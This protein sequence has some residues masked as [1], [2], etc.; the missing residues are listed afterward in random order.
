MGDKRWSI[1]AVVLLL[2]GSNA[3][4]T[5]PANPISV[6]E[7]IADTVGIGLDA[8]ITVRVQANQD[9]NSVEGIIC[10]SDGFTVVSQL[11]T[12][13]GSL[14]GGKTTLMHG[15]IQPAQ[16]GVWIL[17]VRCFGETEDS[18]SVASNDRVVLHISDTLCGA[19]TLSQYIELVGEQGIASEASDSQSAVTTEGELQPP[20]GD[21][22]SLYDDDGAFLRS[23][24]TF[25]VH[26]RLLYQDPGDS[27]GIFRPAVNVWV[28]VMDSDSW[29]GADDY[30]AHGVFDWGGYFEITGIPNDDCSGSV[31][32]YIKFVTANSEFAVQS[33]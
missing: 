2:V 15:S 7:I 8:T 31:D 33:R 14:E 1:I 6:A 13:T 4:A 30:I 18:M 26:G 20:L 28:K 17:E 22:D 27:I 29:C 25:S 24:E 16:S 11:D 9:L 12:K 5:P 3:S 23:G 19:F 21:L 32:P 10:E